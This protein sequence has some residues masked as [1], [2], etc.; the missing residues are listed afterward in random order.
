MGRGSLAYRLSYSASDSN[1]CQ[2]FS[3]WTLLKKGFHYLQVLQ[4]RVCLIGKWFQEKSLFVPVSI[5]VGFNTFGGPWFTKTLI[6]THQVFSIHI[7]GLEIENV[8]CVKKNP[9]ETAL[10]II[11][12]RN[13]AALW[14]SK[15]DLSLTEGLLKI[16]VSEDELLRRMRDGWIKL[17]S[18]KN[19]RVYLTLQANNSK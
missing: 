19:T 7:A 11:I 18:F 17:T 2:V 4:R 10:K 13:M 15:C 8:K 5:L 12:G 14:I 16:K 1:L 6:F 3:M 9:K